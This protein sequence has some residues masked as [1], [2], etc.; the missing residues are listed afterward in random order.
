MGDVALCQTFNSFIVL[1]IFSAVEA[2][3][4]SSSD[5]IRPHSVF[6]TLFHSNIYFYLHQFC[7]C[8]DIKEVNTLSVAVLLIAA[9]FLI[10]N[11]Q[12]SPL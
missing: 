3:Q 10:I 4:I 12:C 9:D 8:I 11:T 2:V 6:K 1:F 7:V 5:L